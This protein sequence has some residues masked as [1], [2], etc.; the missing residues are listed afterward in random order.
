[1]V[2][3]GDTATTDA[4]GDGATP[5]DP[6]ET[7]LFNWAWSGTVSIAE[8]PVQETSPAGF[9]FLGLQITISAPD[10]TADDPL[11]VLFRLDAS[12]IP[13][14]NNEPIIQIFKNGVLVPS[15][16]GGPGTADPDPCVFRRLL[17]NDGDQEFTVFTST[18]SEWNF[19]VAIPPA[20]P[21]ASGPT[22][23]FPP[24]AGS[25]G[26]QL[27]V[28]V[29]LGAIAAAVGGGA[30][31]WATFM[32]PKLGAPA[33]PPSSQRPPRGDAIDGKVFVRPTLIGRP[34]RSGRRRSQ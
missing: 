16:E 2:S 9:E 15:C 34:R 3:P 5:E 12:L 26:W 1:M 4:E 33:G 21:P 30:L 28:L 22:G 7:S 6:V 27:I 23:D 17:M 29:A 18:A 13:D 8:G 10:A 14:G 11:I 25:V 32:R 31:G 19:G 24:Q 20:S